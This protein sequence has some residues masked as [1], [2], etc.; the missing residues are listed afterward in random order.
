M[1]KK[2]HKKRGEYFMDYEE[3]LDGKV[4]LVEDEPSHALLISYNLESRGMAVT[5]F[6][7]GGKFLLSEHDSNFDLIIINVN[8][9][10]VEGLELCANIRSR[11]LEVPILFVTT[12]S[13]V[14]S[15]LCSDNALDY[16]VKPFS[17]KELMEKV[18]RL[19]ASHEWKKEY[20]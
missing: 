19:L 20:V 17:I 14:E 5:L 2:N 6:E 18:T 10:D 11:K 12:S 9:H 7:S 15:C 16:L 4:A 13:S 3:L 1:L 8:L